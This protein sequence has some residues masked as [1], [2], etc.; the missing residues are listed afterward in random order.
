MAGR[1]A[2]FT[3]PLADVPA[4]WKPSWNVSPGQQVLILRKR[5]G[6]LVC[7]Q[8]LWN[9]TP[10]WLNDLSRAPFSTNAEYMLDKPMYRQ[11]LVERRCIIPV[12]GYFAWRQ[13]GKR[14]QPWYLRRRHGG[15]ALA[16]IWERYRLDKDT[17]WDSC[18][19]ITAPAKGLPTKVGTRMPVMLNA[20]EQAI[21]MA[22]ATAPSALLP[23]LLNADP[24]TDMMYPVSTAVSSP[25]TQGAH[26]CTPYGQIVTTQAPA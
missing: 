23:L 9:L 10:G 18:A 22:N 1:L 8:V 20:G 25:A 13:Q 6:R 15:L 19:V 5:D 16:G 14:K 3:P 12:D 17:Y 21:W 7:D 24:Q 11:P 26:C 4:G 2:Q